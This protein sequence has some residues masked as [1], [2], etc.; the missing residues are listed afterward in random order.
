MPAVELRPPAHVTSPGNRLLPTGLASC[1]LKRMPSFHLGGATVRNFPAALLLA[2]CDVLDIWSPII[3][4]VRNTVR[5]SVFVM[6]QS[7]SAW[8]SKRPASERGCRY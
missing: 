4:F 2:N 1:G 7:D 3:F 6:A 5:G 8:K